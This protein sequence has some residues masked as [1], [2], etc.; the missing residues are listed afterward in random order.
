MR[1]GRSRALG[2]LSRT[3]GMAKSRCSLSVS[4]SVAVSV[5]VSVSCVWV[6]VRLFPPPF[7]PSSLPPS[8]HPRPPFPSF[9]RKLT[10]SSHAFLADACK[11]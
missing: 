7:P 1:T 8:L 2:W 5:S 3:A 10:L 11:N 4:V 6:C 9:L